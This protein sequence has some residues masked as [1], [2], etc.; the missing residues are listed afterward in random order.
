MDQSK[1]ISSELESFREQWRAEV[2]A[3][4][5]TG[6][7]GQAQPAQPGPSSSTPAVPARS[8]HRTSAPPRHLVASHQKPVAKEHDDDDFQ[9]Q[10]YDLP[11]ED[12]GPARPSAAAVVEEPVTALEHYEKAVERETQGSLG[13]SLQLYR[14]A[15][16]MDPAVDKKYK[17]KHFPAPPKP[18]AQSSHEGQ[19]STAQAASTTAP[20]ATAANPLDAQ[21]PTMK[22]LIASFQGLS[23]EPAVPEVEGMPQPPCPIADLPQEILVHI[24]HDVAVADVADFVRLAQVCKRLAYLV[25][26]E[27]Q[28]WRSVC[29]ESDFGFPAMHRTWQKSISWGPADD[30]DDCDE[31]EEEELDP[32]NGDDDA[33]TAAATIFLTPEARAAASRA[34]ALATTASLLRGPRYRSSWQRMFRQRPRV[35][36]NGCYIST[37]NYIRSG[38]ASASQVTWNSPVHIVTYFRYLRL[39]RD[40]TAISLLTTAE[41]QDVVHHL[42]RDALA[43]HAG[44]GAGAAGAG[45]H[46]PSAVMQHALRGRWRLGSVDAAAA[47]SASAGDKGDDPEADL[48]VE[49]EGVGKYLYRLELALRSAGRAGGGTR[50]NKLVWRGFYSYN[51]LTDDWAEFGLKNDKPFF[52]SRVKS[53][54]RGD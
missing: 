12:T 7:A 50:N 35:R 15:F 6:T 48:V 49:T 39:L 52:F 14:K 40:G 26:T 46:L 34:A 37:V 54:G 45:S 25:T 41:P 3:K 9:A 38:Q 21:P 1:D 32:E 53:Y 47:A 4:K 33:A 24:M 31:E 51:R 8:H 17:N 16:R 22:E 2:R 13:D 11:S 36:F 23:I 30:D 42:A 44:P 27:D 29:L 10:S 18:A 5:P 20:G 19:P 43:L 28:I